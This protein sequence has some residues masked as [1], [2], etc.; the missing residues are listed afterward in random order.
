VA[1]NIVTLIVENP[2][3]SAMAATGTICAIQVAWEFQR[4]F[5]DT[6]QIVKF[7]KSDPSYTFRNTHAI[8]A[9]TNLPRARIELLCASSKKI[10]RN[11]K[12]RESW[13]IASKEE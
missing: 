1:I 5:R 8:S 4:D 9:S 2:Y 13:C 6:R 11:M 12:E 10:K 7:L 3:V